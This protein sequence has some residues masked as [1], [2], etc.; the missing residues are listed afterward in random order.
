M[1]YII[2]YFIG[3]VLF[4]L[5]M[6][7]FK[8]NQLKEYYSWEEVLIQIVVSFTSWLGVIIWCI[9]S[10]NINLKANPPKWL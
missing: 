6:R 4:Y 9:M 8:R 5:I 1:W 2:I 3:L 10:I 7:K